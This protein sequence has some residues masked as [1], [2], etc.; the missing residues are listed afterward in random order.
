[1]RNIKLYSAISLFLLFFQNSYSQFTVQKVNLNSN[2]INSIFQ[3]TGVFNQNTFPSYAP[4][5]EW[6]INSTNHAIASTGINLAAYLNGQL[7][8]AASSFSGEYVP[9][10]VNNGKF[11]TNNAFK[12]YTIKAGDSANTNP[13]YANWELMI[14]YGAP[15]IDVNSNGSYETGIDKPGIKDAAQVIFV[16]LTD[17]L[18]GHHH[19]SGFG[20]GTAPLLA[21]VALTA[22][23]YTSPDLENAQFIKCEI[24]NKSSSNWDSLYF[25]IFC[26]ADLGHDADDYIGC[27]TIRNLAYC[28]NGDNDDGNYGIA[29]PAVGFTLLRGMIDRSISPAKPLFMT[30]FTTSYHSSSAYCEFIHYGCAQCAYNFMKGYK[31]DMSPW[32]NPITTPLSPVKFIYSGDPETNTGWWEGRGSVYNCGGSIGNTIPANYP[33]KRMFNMASGSKSLKMNPNEKQTIVFAQHI[34]R[35]STNLHSVTKLKDASED[36]RFIFD[37]YIAPNIGVGIS[38]IS[39]EIPEGFKLNQNYP[40][41]FNPSTKISFAIPKSGFVNLKIY[42]MTGREIT[43]LVNEQLQTGSYEVDFN[44]SHLSSGVY[45]YKLTSGNFSEVK[46]M[47]LV[48]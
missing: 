38:N 22:W 35:G 23:C 9:G 18:T 26:D 2:N 8:M 3:N 29:P 45:Y 25:S 13:D 39:S 30:S 48:K 47:M 10:Y 44:A 43:N 28:Y 12:I 19:G 27:D 37:N 46:K 42:D 14:N 11:V 24:T 32:Y 33:G 6:P 21:Q 16:C 31:S 4:A 1:M 15:F 34:A 41:P 5:F 20:G 36:I 7:R 40:N 17:A